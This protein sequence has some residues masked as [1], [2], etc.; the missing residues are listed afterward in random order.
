[1][2]AAVATRT[3][4]WDLV[5]VGGGFYGCCIALHAARRWALRRVL[6]VEREDAL[7]QRASWRNQA[8]VHGGY[9]YPRSYT[10]AF[11]SRFN[12]PRFLQDWPDATRRDMT[13]LYAIARRGSRVTARQFERFAHDVGAPLADADAAQVQWFDPAR[14]ERVYRV[15]ETVFDA[16]ALADSVQREL[17]D[18][19]IEVS[20]GTHV[21]EVSGPGADGLCLRWR[22]GSAE[23]QWLAHRVL[24]CTYAGLLAVAGRDSGLEGSIKLELVELPLVRTPPP[25]A[26]VGI[27]VMDGPFFSL[28]PFPPRPG[29]H[30]LSH[31]RYTPH[32]AWTPVGGD[33]PYRLLDG[34]AEPSRFERMR[35]DASLYMPMLRE[36]VAEGGLMELK[37]VPTRNEV[38]DGRPILVHSHAR[39]PGFYSV[40]GGKIDNLRDVLERLGDEAPP[41][42]R[43]WTH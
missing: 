6:L 43:P 1:M 28:Q 13:A 12:Y 9:H 21:A 15:V 4:A 23:G 19:G 20:L 24:N 7:L 39:L 5:V 18:T 26:D 14:I 33:D 11:R 16:S 22:T 42:S 31:V 8:R 38:D 32:R 30:T 3:E 35:R 27:T 10:T 34:H 37:A 36:L 2:T 17:A 40:L 41:G 29:L 25:L